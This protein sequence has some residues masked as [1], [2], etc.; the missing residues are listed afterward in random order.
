[1]KVHLGA[2]LIASTFVFSVHSSATT[3][4]PACGNERTV[5]DVS[6][7]KAHPAPTVPEAGK[8]QV[9]FIEIADKNAL[10]VTTRVGLDGTWVG[11]NKGSSYFESTVLPGEH[12]VCADWQL[13]H[14]YLKDSPALD[15]FTAEAGKTYYFVVKVGWTAN[16][17]PVQYM[18]YDGDMKLELSAANEDEGKYMV[19]NSK[20]STATQKQ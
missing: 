7:H 13:A 5:I 4:P 1:M 11:A 2:A 19:Q 20:F 6:T 18:R 16:V 15:V 17:S 9:V 8:A 3:L 14:R 10:P 12:H